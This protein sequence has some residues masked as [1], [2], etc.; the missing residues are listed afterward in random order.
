M[1][2]NEIKIL[3]ETVQVSNDYHNIYEL[4]FLKDNPRVYSCIYEEPDFEDLPEAVQQEKIFEKLQ[5]E[6]SV[7]NLVREIERHGG[8]MERILVRLDTMQVIEGNSRLAVYRILYEKTKKEDWEL[9]PCDI[10]QTLSDEQQI[11]YL[12][13]IHVKGKTEWSAYEKANFAYARKT[14]GF[15]L[16]KIAKLFGESEGTIRTRIKVVETMRNNND[17]DRSHFS[18]YDVLVRNHS[19]DMN[20]RPDLK[21]ALLERIRNLGD[22]EEED[23]DFTAQELRKKLPAIIKKPKVLNKYIEGTIGLDNAYQ[24]AKISNVQERIREAKAILE[25][26]EKKNVKKLDKNDLNAFRQDVR[27]LEREVGRIVRMT[28]EAN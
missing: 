25:G 21:S 1:R 27:K 8:L 14:Q 11:A 3:R 16:P 7:K 23:L 26:I 5:A 19:S 24:R 20:Q 10:V 18:H 15:P 13:Q 4:R 12:N 17:R 2:E 9:I 28:N 22:N 6:P